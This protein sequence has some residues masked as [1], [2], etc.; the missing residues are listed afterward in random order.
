MRTNL[1]SKR[2]KN[3]KDDVESLDAIDIDDDGFIEGDVD[4]GKPIVSFNFASNINK[5]DEVA[6]VNP[7]TISTNADTVS[8]STDET[9]KTLSRGQTPPIDGEQF[10]MKRCY[11]FRP[12]TLKKLNELKANHCDV[13]V[14]LS[15]LVDAAIMHYYSYIFKEKE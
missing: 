15:T 5:I 13:N 11:Q 1:N 10:S 14:Y 6:A 4:F 3:L 8:N 7:Q 2:K 9:I 12:S